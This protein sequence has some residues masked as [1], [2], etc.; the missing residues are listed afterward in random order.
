MKRK[1]V[2][3]TAGFVL[4]FAII[5]VV[6][7]FRFDLSASLGPVPSSDLARPPRRPAASEVFTPAHGSVADAVRDFFGWRPPPIQPVAFPHKLHLA[8]GF[9]CESCHPGAAGGPVAGL[10]GVKFCMSC[11]QLYATDSPEVRKLAG[12]LARG[13]EVPWQ[14]VYGFSPMAHVRFNHAPHIRA[15]VPCSACH[16]DLSQQTV[17]RLA[18][19]LNMGACLDCHRS[20]KASTDCTTCHF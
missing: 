6:L 7:A 3:I 12:Y 13:E 19:N 16:G 1:Q 18:V 14:R 5:L 2:I 4:A 8:K 20:R 9:K 15:G 10:P 17:A 11:H